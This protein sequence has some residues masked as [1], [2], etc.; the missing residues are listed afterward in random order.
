MLIVLF[1]PPGAGKGTQASPVAE[2][3]GVPKLATGDVL[4]AAVRDGT[5]RGLEAKAGCDLVE[6]SLFGVHL[7]RQQF[8]VAPLL[9][10]RGQAAADRLVVGDG[11]GTNQSVERLRE[12]LLVLQDLL[13]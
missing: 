8:M 2:R 10:Q 5:P 4:R 13:G 6:Q 7:A 1:G 12:S 3:L 9:R 11:A